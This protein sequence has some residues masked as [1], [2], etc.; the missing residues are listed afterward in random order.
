MSLGNYEGFVS[1]VEDKQ[2]SVETTRDSVL[3]GSHYSGKLDEILEV[4]NS[5]G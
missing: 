3:K 5:V 2:G 1:T 4:P